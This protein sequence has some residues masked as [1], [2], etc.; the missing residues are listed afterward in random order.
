MDF[1]VMLP[2]L[3]EG[4]EREGIRFA[5]IGGLAVAAYGH[6]RTTLDADFL[7][8]LDSQDRAVALLEGLGYET[9]HRSNAFSNHLHADVTKGRVDLMYVRRPT[10]DEIFARCELRSLP[11]DLVA[12]IASPEHIAA[13]KAFA[14]AENPGRFRDLEDVLYLLRRPGVDRDEIRRQFERRGLGERY[15]ELENLL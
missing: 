7:V 2:V 5:V 12:P 9:L 13:M 1:G 15:R 3:V 14:L 4:F 6:D 11:R 8:D 10:A